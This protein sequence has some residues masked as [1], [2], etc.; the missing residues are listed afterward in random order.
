[1]DRCGCMH[2]CDPAVSPS[3]PRVRRRHRQSHS[4]CRKDL[5]G[6]ED[7]ERTGKRMYI[8]CRCRNRRPDDGFEVIHTVYSTGGIA[9]E[10][11]TQSHAP[12]KHR[13]TIYRYRP[14]I[15]GV[16]GTSHR[17][18]SKLPAYLPDQESQSAY[19][20]L[21]LL[22][23]SRVDLEKRAAMRAFLNQAY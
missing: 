1:M 16:Q 22:R 17:I 19:L 15:V 20:I 6:W 3:F 10:R 14:E 11:V 2:L 21:S 4:R 5:T 23:C 12:P 18:A 9:A 7:M 13:P 8:I